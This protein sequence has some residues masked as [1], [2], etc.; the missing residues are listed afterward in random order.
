MDTLRG[1][2][3]SIC[4]LGSEHGFPKTPEETWF[5]KSDVKRL[6]P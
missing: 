3:M 2:S 1:A 4:L 5:P 6:E